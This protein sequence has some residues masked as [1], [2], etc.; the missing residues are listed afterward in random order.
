MAL[1]R[2][3]PVATSGHG[4]WTARM[5]Y[6]KQ[7]AAV[8]ADGCHANVTSRVG[9]RHSGERASHPPP[10]I[11]TSNR[12]ARSGPLTALVMDKIAIT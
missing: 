4:V 10:S 11:P 9:A 7:G 1:A 5:L 3:V 6:S 12:Q 2:R 8:A